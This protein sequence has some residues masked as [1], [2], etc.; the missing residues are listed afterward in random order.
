MKSVTLKCWRTLCGC[1]LISAASIASAED[2]DPIVAN[3]N[4]HEIRLSYVYEQ[5]EGV[6]LGD[7][8]SV[9]QNLPRF[10]E[11]I[12]REEILYQS[13]LATDFAQEAELRQKIKS[14]IVEHLITR[15]V[16]AKKKHV[17]EQDIATYYETNASAIRGES[18]RAS[19]IV[20]ADEQDCRT[21]MSDIRSQEQFA[22]IAKEQS[23][24][25]ATRERDGDMGYFMNHSGALGF[26]PDLFDMQ[27]DEMRVF[28]TAQGCHLV[29][30]TE[31]ESPP[32]P[33]LAEVS[34]RIRELLER[35]RERDLLKALLDRSEPGIDVTRFPLQ[36]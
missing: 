32:M 18:V 27:P 28:N 6:A 31:H 23:I 14:M 11:S 19:Q 13:M 29:R 10:I 16:E 22:R 17:T 25:D 26:E 34:D 20:L 24:D 30:L 4:G 1:L 5:I 35:E 8:L 7:Q 12:V 15:H 3:V 2:E 33:P 36:P 9:R 21:L